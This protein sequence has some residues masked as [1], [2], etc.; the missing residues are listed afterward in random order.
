LRT[1]SIGVDPPLEPLLDPL[2]LGDFAF[3]FDFDFDELDDF[4]LDLFADFGLADFAFFA[5]LGFAAFDFDF[6]V[7]G[8]EALGFA[9][10][11]DCDFGFAFDSLDEPA[12]FEAGCFLDLVSAIFLS[13]RGVPYYVRYPIQCLQITLSAANSA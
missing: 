5:A 10:D 6:A 1:A 9:F 2:G 11:F 3:G 7:F 8:F 12:L 4:G 13:P